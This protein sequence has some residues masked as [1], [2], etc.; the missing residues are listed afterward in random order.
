MDKTNQVGVLGVMDAA[1]EHLIHPDCEQMTQARAAVAR[2]LLSAKQIAS[3]LQRL[4]A[5]DQADLD[6][7]CA[8]IAGVEGGAP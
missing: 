4:G 1:S 2:L 7:L 6:E 5:I 3:D 8:A